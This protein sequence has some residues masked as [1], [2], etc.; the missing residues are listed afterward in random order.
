MPFRAPGPKIRPGHEDAASGP[1]EPETEVAQLLR[2]RP[3]TAS[4]PC[5]ADKHAGEG[6]D[7]HFQLAHSRRPVHTTA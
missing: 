5:D 7:T 2:H 6:G 4:E 1:C 3:T